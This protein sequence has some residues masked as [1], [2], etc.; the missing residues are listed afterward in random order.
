[1]AAGSG[2]R[3]TRSAVAAGA[4]GALP[5]LLRVARRSGVSP[6]DVQRS[7]A[8][9]ALIADPEIQIDRATV[10][11]APASGVWPWLVQLG[12]GRAGWYMPSWLERLAVWPPEKRSAKRIVDELQS[13]QAGDSVP[14]WGPGDPSFKVIELAPP[15]ALVYLSLRDRGRNWTWPTDDRPPSEVMAFSWALVLDEIDAERCRLH[16]RLRGRFGKRGRLRPLL[17]AL[18]GLADY[19]TIIVMFAGLKQRVAQTRREQGPE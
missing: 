12:K 11:G 6:A 17:V 7:L 2:T 8:G 5:A 3:G 9:D 16:I 10:I 13:L 18:G 1:M 4:A 14:D 19:L 15:R